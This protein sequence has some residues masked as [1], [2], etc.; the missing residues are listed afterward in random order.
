ME[1]PGH[2]A[3]VWL[4]NAVSRSRSQDKKRGVG[5]L[6]GWIQVALGRTMLAALATMEIIIKLSTCNDLWPSSGRPRG[7]Q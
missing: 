5:T 1:T 6:D 7:E 3:G 2:K 4:S